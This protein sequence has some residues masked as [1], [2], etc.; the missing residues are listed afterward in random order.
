MEPL[1]RLRLPAFLL[2]LSA[3]ACAQQPVGE[4]FA[5]DA[6][7]HGS[8]QLTGG[9]MQVMS[10]ANVSAGDA[11]ASLK[12][13]RGGQVR[14]CPGT[15]I[16]VSAGGSGQLM[17]GMGTGAVETDYEL[18]T[19]ADTIVTPDFRILLAGPGRF[20]FAIAARRN[21]DTCVQARS[22]NTA[23]LIVHEMMG[24][25]TYQVKPNQS[26]LFRGGRLGDA[27]P[28]PAEDCGCPPPA[29]VQRAADPPSPQP[30][31]EAPVVAAAGVEP[32]LRDPEAPPPE[33]GNPVQVEVDSPFIFRAE[34][35]PPP[36]PEAQ[37]VSLASLPALPGSAVLPPAEV[38][39]TQAAV[40]E[41]PK[42]KKKKGWFAR[43]AAGIASIF[44]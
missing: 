4:V 39:V 34:D 43:L 6:T 14:V 2:A 36:A 42:P 20:Q 25:A 24:D 21:G 27:L 35:V 22:S 5:S 40:P 29:P 13:A 10:G 37:R 23:A 17:L 7:V 41:A 26:V 3:L 8:V 44:K 12:L 11:A 1:R 38:T 28:N 9:G 19:S 32:R 16:S 18:A 33:S 15:S 30:Q 31:P